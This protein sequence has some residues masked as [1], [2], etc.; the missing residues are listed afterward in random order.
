MMTEYIDLED[1]S[2]TSFS[3]A[4]GKTQVYITNLNEDEILNLKVKYSC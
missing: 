1:P 2:D 4:I 3:S